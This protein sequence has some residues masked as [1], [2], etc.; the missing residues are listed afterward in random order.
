MSFIFTFKL[1]KIYWD[2]MTCKIKLFQGNNGRIYWK[3]RRL[4]K[5]LFITFFIH[6][7]KQ[8]LGL[9]FLDKS[10]PFSENFIFQPNT[11]VMATLS[12]PLMNDTGSF[13]CE[14]LNDIFKGT[15]KFSCVMMH[16]NWSLPR[17][18]TTKLIDC[19]YANALFSLLFDI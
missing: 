13:T 3:N 2:F 6:F 5:F 11:S 8:N 12:N 17:V 9:D 1:F 14:L 16:L 19:K 10:L 18:Y 15:F 7:E 4:T